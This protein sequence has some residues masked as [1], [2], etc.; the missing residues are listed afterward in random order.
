MAKLPAA[1]Q[2]GNT[3]FRR[4]WR[5]PEG[6]RTLKIFNNEYNFKKNRKSEDY[7]ASLIK[8]ISNTGVLES[9]GKTKGWKGG[10]G[11]KFLNLCQKFGFITPRPAV[12]S[13]KGIYDLNENGE[14]NFIIEFLN[15]TNSNIKLDKSP[16]SLTPLGILLTETESDEYEITNEQKDIFL[17]SLYYQKQPSILHSL[18]NEYKGEVIRPLQLFLQIFFKLEELKMETSLSTGEI[19]LVINTSWTNNLENIIKELKTFRKNKKGKERKFSKEWFD[20]RGGKNIFKVNFDSIWTYADPNISYLVSTGLINKIGKKIILNHDKKN[21]SKII[22]EESDFSFSNDFEYLLN[23]W[24][25]KLLPFED[26]EFLINRAINNS[27]LLNKKFNYQDK[28]IFNKKN[29]EKTDLSFLTN[30]TSKKD[31]KSLLKARKFVEESLQKVKK[32]DPN[33]KFDKEHYDFFTL[34]VF[35][36]LNPGSVKKIIYKTEDKIKQFNEIEFFEAQKKNSKEISD[37]LI[38]INQKNN[39]YY[40]GIDFEAEPEHLEWIIWRSF[41][42]INS[43]LNKIKDTRGFPIDENFLPTHHAPGGKEDLFFEFDEYCLIIEVT[44]KTGGSQFKDEVEPVYR[45]TAKKMNLYKNKQVY[46]LFIA[47]QIDLNLLNS[48]QRNYYDSQN[49]EYSGNII[50]MTLEQFTRIFLELFHKKKSLTPLI[51]KDIFDKILLQKI[52]KKPKEWQV[53]INNIIEEKILER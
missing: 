15:H 1:L 19:S 39:I 18:G 6:L 2:I 17:R 40:N 25:G 8:A 29:I 11:R 36:T 5:I 45:H 33:F 4:P 23:F 3:T 30:A 16:F 9:H 13:G 28:S 21:I 34:K 26:K 41:L 22:A 20:Q 31:I 44:F 24:S 46:C 7:E 51:F 27:Q 10:H 35:E 49:Y 38:N 48:F 53:Y 43:F 42:A 32:T 12:I 50:P 47:P 14:D 37:T 52:E